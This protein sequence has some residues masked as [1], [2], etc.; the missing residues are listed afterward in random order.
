MEETK[1][2]KF[3]RLAESRVN[4]ALKQIE[5]VGNLANKRIYDYSESDVEQ[6]L[7]ALKNSVNILEGKFRSDDKSSNKFRI[8]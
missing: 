2:E 7:R 5:L 3:V 8:K 1:R 6:I 4:N